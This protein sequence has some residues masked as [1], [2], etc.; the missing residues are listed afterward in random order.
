VRQVT[1]D[2]SLNKQSDESLKPMKDPNKNEDFEVTLK[3]NEGEVKIKE[4]Q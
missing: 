3:I 4:E 2:F 1:T